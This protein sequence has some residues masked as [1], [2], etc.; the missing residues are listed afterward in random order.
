MTLTEAAFW[1]KRVGVILMVMV[2]IFLI[3]AIIVTTRSN[4]PL[5]PEY[6]EANYACT[7][8]KE[9]FL[10]HRLEIPSLE[11]A[12]DSEQVFDVKTE[13]GKV[14]SLS[15]IKIINVHSYKESLQLLSNQNVA[16]SLA[17]DL[18]FDPEAIF[19]RGTT[20]YIWTSNVNK[21][22]LTVDAKT[23]NFELT[24]EPAYIREVAR[25]QSVPTESQA[26]TIAINA[27]RRLN[28]LGS[29]FDLSDSTLVTTQYVDINPDGS[30]SQTTNLGD[31]E[32]IKVNFKR[33]R[34]MVSIKEN[35]VGSEAMVRSLN[36]L[37][38]EA[39]EDTVIINDT[40]I[41]IFNYSTLIVHTNPVSSNVVVYVGPED[42]NSEAFNNIY[43]IELR[44]WQLNSEHC[45]TYELISPAAA[46][47]GV[48]NGDGSLVYLNEKGGD[49]IRPYQPKSVRKFT[50]FYIE[51]VYYEPVNQPFF[52]Q[53][54]YLI[55]GD[56]LFQNGTTGEFHFYYPAINYDIVQDKIEQVAPE[57]DESKGQGLI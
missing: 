44:Y 36:N 55:G 9:D 2:G 41:K 39:T 5:P 28:V 31:A 6:L 30:F 3:F 7:E 4:A 37:M 21:R 29:D 54:V 32:L 43:K 24:T 46:I 22:S 10:A 45:G 1:T 19:R 57:I 27:L 33:L 13:T 50:I 38:G 42:P 20:D 14:N 23:L 48:Q 49:E 51:L 52:L 11:L 26:K 8:K 16:K 47:E 40:R 18:G 25:E 17:S 56:A 15:D 53:P 35:I 34:P 12:A